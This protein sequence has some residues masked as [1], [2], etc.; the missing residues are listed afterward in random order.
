LLKLLQWRFGYKDGDFERDPKNGGWVE[1]EGELAWENRPHATS[2]SSSRR[3]ERNSNGANS[4]ASA[5]E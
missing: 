3:R 5:S 2:A 4:S 1:G